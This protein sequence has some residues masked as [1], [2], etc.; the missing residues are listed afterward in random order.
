MIVKRLMSHDKGGKVFLS[1]LLL[2][3]LLVPIANL[4]APPD[5]IFH[6]TTYSVTLLGKYLCYALLAIS[7]DLVW[8]YCGILSLGHGEFFALGGY[9]MG[10]YLMRQIGTEVFMAT[11][12]CRTLW[13]FLTGKVFHGIGSDWISFGSLGL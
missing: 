8:G 6:V 1:V 9:V 2:L 13:Y 12:S 7:L 4:L 10:M 3:W 11:L 5:S